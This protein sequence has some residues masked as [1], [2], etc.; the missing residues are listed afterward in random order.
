MK[1]IASVCRWHRLLWLYFGKSK[2]TPLQN[3][4][5][6]RNKKQIHCIKNIH[7]LSIATIIAEL[8]GVCACLQQPLYFVHTISASQ[9]NTERPRRTTMHIHSYWREVYS[10]RF[11]GTA[12]FFG[13]WNEAKELKRNSCQQR[14]TIWS[15]FKKCNALHLTCVCVAY[16]TSVNVDCFHNW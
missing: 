10:H 15:H 14:E 8:S 11:M 13:L 5:S 16:L 9:G 2:N 1:H 4:W 6:L 3:H 7:P 12:I